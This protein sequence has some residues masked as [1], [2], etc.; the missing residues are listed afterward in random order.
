[1]TTTYS[2]IK[3][4]V[5]MQESQTALVVICNNAF[6]LSR[7]KEKPISPPITKD[8]FTQS[9]PVARGS[10]TNYRIWDTNCVKSLHIEWPYSE[11]FSMQDLQ[12]H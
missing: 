2:C 3:Y 10:P 6:S 5:F 4:L 11:V 8:E 9:P 7:N 1:M 12:C